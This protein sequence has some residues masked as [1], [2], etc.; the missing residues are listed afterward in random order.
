[1]QRKK[2]PV[3]WR[4]GGGVLMM[5]QRR[6]RHTTYVVNV[7]VYC[8]LM[9]IV[10]KKL[11]KGLW[12]CEGRVSKARSFEAPFGNSLR[13]S[14]NI[15]WLVGYKAGAKTKLVFETRQ[16]YTMDYTHV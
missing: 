5:I 6:G 9:W 7:F 13:D 1:M 14:S 12:A 15:F 8:I 2:I 4:N 16:G 11:L 3:F 10:S